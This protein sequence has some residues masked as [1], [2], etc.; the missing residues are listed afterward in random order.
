MVVV[1]V[2]VAKIASTHLLP[3]PRQKEQW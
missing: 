2:V 1:V 3:E